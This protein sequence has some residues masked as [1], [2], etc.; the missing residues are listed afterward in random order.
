MK[1]TAEQ[2]ALFYSGGETIRDSAWRGIGLSVKGPEYYRYTPALETLARRV[3]IISSENTSDLMARR[4]KVGRG[5]Q[6]RVIRK[7]LEK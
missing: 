3:G 1:Q 4:C 5:K 6:G 2:L 7:R